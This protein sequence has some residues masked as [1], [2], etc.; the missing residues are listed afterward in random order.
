MNK[1]QQKRTKGLLLLVGGLSWLLV[2]ILGII[3]T[4]PSWLPPVVKRLAPEEFDEI[5]FKV[6][7]ISLQQILIKDLSVRFENTGLSVPE[8]KSTF[9]VK[10]L[11]SG[12]LESI[13]INNPTLQLDLSKTTSSDKPQD[14]AINL[15][16][17]LNVNLPRIPINEL[18]IKDMELNL[19]SSSGHLLK[20]V[21]NF[22]GTQK[23]MRLNALA[24][25]TYDKNFLQFTAL[26]QAGKENLRALE[27]SFDCP[28]PISLLDSILPFLPPS[29]QALSEENP[30]S[31]IG[32]YGS[33]DWNSSDGQI[34]F[35]TLTE[36]LNYQESVRGDT[37]FFNATSIDYLE[38]II[39]ELSVEHLHIPGVASASI[40]SNSKIQHILL[41]NPSVETT[42][43]LSEI[44]VDSPSTQLSIDP[45][46]LEIQYQKNHVN[47]QIPLIRSPE[48]PLSLR[49]N[50]IQINMSQDKTEITSY[51]ELAFNFPSWTILPIE[52]IPTYLKSN[53]ILHEGAD[54]TEAIS[55][56][57][58]NVP[59]SN[60]TYSSHTG[61]SFET[62]IAGTV[63]VHYSEQQ[64]DV[65]TSIQID[66]FHYNDGEG[67]LVE[68]AFN[69]QASFKFTD[70]LSPESFNPLNAIKNLE[71]EST[72]EIAGSWAEIP[73]ST[74]NL[75]VAQLNE[76]QSAS[77]GKTF[78]IHADNF[79][80]NQFQ[81]IQPEG[82]VTIT[83]DTLSARIRANV[84]NQDLISNI[85][86]QT[87]FKSTDFSAHIT[88]NP[89]SEDLPTTL[90]LHEIISGLQ[91][92]IVSGIFNTSVNIQGQTDQTI[93]EV[94]LQIN[95]GTLTLPESEIS[96]SGI[97]FN[98][99]LEDAL[100]GMGAANQCL[101]IESIKLNDVRINNIRLMFQPLD[102]FAL[103]IQQL[104]FEF[105]DG[106]FD[107]SLE[108]PLLITDPSIK[109]Q[110]HFTGV[111]LSKLTEF[112]PDFNDEICGKIKG[113]LPVTIHKGIISWGNG[114]AN[115]IPGTTG[116]MR[117]AQNGIIDSYIP[118]ITIGDNIDINE[119]LRDITLTQLRFAIQSSEDFAKP[120]TII[121]SGYSNN[122]S[123]EIPIE[124][125]QLNVRAPD[126]PDLLNRTL[127]KST[128]IQK[129]IF[130]NEFE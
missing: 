20:P 64:A 24:T 98:L 41:G 84:M 73:F 58:L 34:N 74:S 25:L 75:F 6:E 8:L 106:S 27:I 125:I 91:E 33:L 32:L 49:Q 28:N 104:T 38:S 115:L 9:R 72:P 1:K 14:E 4:L 103:R 87:N 26:Q 21:I 67:L 92:T 55:D 81:L 124:K 17:I 100:R 37:L 113:Q 40:T 3:L 123:L 48:F 83:S 23:D 86:F 36:T 69:T 71:I 118:E 82:L 89:S 93:I 11:L 101:S 53:N 114:K 44:V 110:I 76:T 122:P 65:T 117:Y 108:E 47:L 112:I 57:V 46:D 90:Q 19:T 116:Q 30:L 7:N 56:I 105:C 94:L 52:T 39:A 54:F 99:M 109:L 16:G 88:V 51:S 95:K 102:G 18:L 111:E 96:I 45:I 10:D 70:I 107:I 120:T 42:L 61:Q 22:R 129:M 128:W 126:L 77:E 35:Q 119:A 13:W 31:I 59:K 79:H 85:D 5:T 127:K 2:T 12:N 121:M 66:S 29:I 68:G 60:I 78:K 50:V 97:Q 80:Y 43:R 63:D 15:H 62:V 130:K